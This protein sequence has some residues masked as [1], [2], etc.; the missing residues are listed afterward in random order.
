MV[1]SLWFMVFGFWFMVF[2]FWLFRCFARLAVLQCYFVACDN[3]ALS[4]LQAT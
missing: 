4:P 2:G 3:A 1:Y